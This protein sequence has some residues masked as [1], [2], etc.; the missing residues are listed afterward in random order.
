MKI[1]SYGIWIVAFY[2]LLIGFAGAD[3]VTDSVQE[4]LDQYKQGN[5][6]EAASSLEYAAQLI[7]QKRSLGLEAYLPE[8]LKGWQGEKA[9]TQA[10]GA[11]M[12]GGMV[13]SSKRYRKD[14]KDVRVE[15]ITDSP[16]LQ[17]MMMMFN[18]PMFAMSDGGKLTK[19]KGQKAIVKYDADNKDGEINLVI[20]GRILVKVDGSNVEEQDL[21]DYA[22]AI[23]YKK[24]S[25]F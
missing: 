1:I 19:I 15:I 3:D 6:N 16:M 2:S 14:D 13:S 12:M 17:G 25:D 20:A 22:S 9:E 10:A 11:A 5:L 18:N 23:D 7:K 8:P 21:M 4:G 24:L